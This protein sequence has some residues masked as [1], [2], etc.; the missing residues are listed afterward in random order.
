MTMQLL[1]SALDSLTVC[2]RQPYCLPMTV[3]LS[4]VEKIWRL[5]RNQLLP[6]DGFSE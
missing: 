6:F 5:V 1:L 2:L 3:I 4:K